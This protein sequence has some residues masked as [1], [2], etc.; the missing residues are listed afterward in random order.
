MTPSTDDER[1]ALEPGSLERLAADWL[2][3]EREVAEGIRNPAQ[4][5]EKARDLS[6]RYDDAIRA[7]T[8]EELRLAWEAARKNQGEREMGS[9][10][11]LEARRISELLRGE[12]EASSP[13]PVEATPE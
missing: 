8:R 13:E 5:E 2:D 3:A 9:E 1:P 4:A 10:A 12:Y 11:W 7:A 6:A